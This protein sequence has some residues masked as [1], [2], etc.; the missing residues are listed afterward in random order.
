MIFRRGYVGGGAS[1]IIGV[2]RCLLVII[3]SPSVRRK[4]KRLRLGRHILPLAEGEEE[5]ESGN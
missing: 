2:F 3:S 5:H 1:G 4:G